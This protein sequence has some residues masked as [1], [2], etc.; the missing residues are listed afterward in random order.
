MTGSHNTP[1]WQG[2]AVA[3]VATISGVALAVG[4]LEASARTRKLERIQVVNLSESAANTIDGVPIW[5]VRNTTVLRQGDACGDATEVLLVGSSILFGSGVEDTESLRPLLM[6]HLP[7]TCIRNLSQPAFTWANQSV[8]LQQALAEHTPAVVVLEIWYNS[9]NAWTVIDDVAYNFGRPA[10]MNDELPSPFGL[11]PTWNRRLFAASA[12]YRHGVVARLQAPSQAPSR[13]KSSFW[14]EWAEQELAP[15]VEKM[16]QAGIIVVL[17]YMPSLDRPFA[18]HPP[19]DRGQMKDV[20]RLL[21]D[22][23]LQ[24]DVAREFAARNTDFIEARHDP[25]CHYSPAG[26]EVLAEILATAIEPLLAPQAGEDGGYGDSK[27]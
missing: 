11:S 4:I 23:V 6:D 24:I 1:R 13:A 9:I 10:A 2:P 27:R 7:G 12:A 26:N 3:M 19:L 5:T 16:Q 15:T 14:R 25:C 8:V 22:S 18:D 20:H 17:A 21:G